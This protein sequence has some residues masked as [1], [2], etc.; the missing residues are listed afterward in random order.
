MS[1]IDISDLDHC[2]VIQGLWYKQRTRFRFPISDAEKPSCK[3]IKKELL[4]DNSKIDYINGYCIKTDFS[5]LGKVDTSTYNSRY[6]CNTG[7]NAFE[8]V[9][10]GLRSRKLARLIAFSYLL[11]MDNN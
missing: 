11:S 2:E 3:I 1:T 4:N 9:V 6:G 8:E 7:E 10:R 5:N